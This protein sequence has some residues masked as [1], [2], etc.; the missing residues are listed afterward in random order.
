MSRL[1]NILFVLALGAVVALSGTTDLFAD[2]PDQ[3]AKDLSVMVRNG[4]RLSL[5]TSE[6]EYS[7]SEYPI[8]ISTLQN[9][10]EKTKEGLRRVDPMKYGWKH[11]AYTP[12]KT[13]HIH[14]KLSGKEVRTVLPGMPAHTYKTVLEPGEKHTD[15]ILFQ[16]ITKDGT[17]P[18]PEGDYKVTQPGFV[19]AEL[20][21]VKNLNRKPISTKG[22]S[23]KELQKILH[24][25][26]TSPGARL[27]LLQDIHASKRKP[28]F[29]QLITDCDDAFAVIMMLEHLDRDWLDI[30]GLKK[31]SR[32]NDLSVRGAA[33]RAF[34][35]LGKNEDAAKWLSDFLATQKDGLVL[36]DGKDA[37]EV[38]QG[39]KKPNPLNPPPMK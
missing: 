18:L 37:L 33:L 11:P 34:S 25:P 7:T 39:T 3:Q 17:K 1:K 12:S 19:I 9:V 10:A 24:D 29:W 14:E 4:I 36:R 35:R 2:S 26:K 15:I 28:V 16:E 38:L 22:M 5:M 13:I 32:S 21:V 30:D 23:E 8:F 27:R 6:R 20:K 31:L